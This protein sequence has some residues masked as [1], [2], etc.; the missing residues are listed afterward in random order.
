MAVG[1]PLVVLLYVLLYSKIR[2]K[3]ALIQ[4]FSMTDTGL[5]SNEIVKLGLF[6]SMF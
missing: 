3:W 6:F 2:K 1:S 4:I 5:I